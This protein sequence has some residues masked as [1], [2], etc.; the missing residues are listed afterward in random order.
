MLWPGRCY[1]RESVPYKALD[2]LIDAL[3]RHLRH[4]PAHEAEALL[5]RDVGPLARVFPV[6]RRVEA[7]ASAPRRAV[8]APDPQELRRRAYAALRELLARLGDRRPLVLAIDDL[9]W[10]D[11]DS[12][13]VL[14][15]VLRPPDTPSCCCWPATGARRPPRARSSAP[16]S[17]R[18]APTASTAATW[19]SGRSRP[20]SRG[21]WP[22]TSS[23]RAGP[24]AE[25]RP[26]PSRGSR[27]A[28]RCS[29]P[30]C[31]VASRGPAGEAA[32]AGRARRGALVAGPSGCPTTPGGCW[33]SWPSRAG[34]SGRT[35]PGSASTGP[36]T[37]GRPSP[38]CGRRGL[39]RGRGG[40]AGRRPGRDVPRPGPRD[41]RGPPLA[42]RA[43]RLPP[44]ARAAPWRPPGEADHEVLGVHFRGAGDAERAGG[45][46]AL[47]AA[48]GGRGPGVRP[49]LGALPAG[50]RTA[51][52]TRPSVPAAPRGAGRGAGQRRPRGRGG[53]RVPRRLRRGDRRRGPGAPPPGRACS[54]S[55]AAT[56]TRGSTPSATC[57]RRSA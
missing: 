46:F 23:R 48:A 17:T 24:D 39:V 12:L 57:W 8:E 7:V 37:S 26:R 49:R 15:E 47:A 6:L 28:T 29:S 31:A 38:C 16:C 56:S 3:S 1:E 2:S 41:G 18:P 20:R 40:A 14:S 54:S 32:G 42:R 51:S 50:P 43:A 13:A 5:P 27:A 35:S 34:R 33:R 4:L 11:A 10:G 55:S 52:R 44:P 9:Q 25:G 30:S 22:G 36:A 21:P 53:A 19:P 45:H